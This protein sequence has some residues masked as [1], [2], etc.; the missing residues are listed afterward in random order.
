TRP[1]GEQTPLA[2]RPR[3]D[4]R[5]TERT[6]VIGETFD[7]DQ[8]DDTGLRRTLERARALSARTDDIEG[9]LGNEPEEPATLAQ[10]LDGLPRLLAGRRPT[11]PVRVLEDEP[12]PAK[13]GGAS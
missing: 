2:A 3:I 13:K 4:V 12:A 5:P 6:A 7:D 9:L 8:L 10:A 1:S 11:G